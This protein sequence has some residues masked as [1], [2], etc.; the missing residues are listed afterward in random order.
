MNSTHTCFI[1]KPTSTYAVYA[2]Q[3][4]LSLNAQWLKMRYLNIITLNDQ[5]KLITD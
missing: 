2:N 5:M 4:V 1:F 3:F